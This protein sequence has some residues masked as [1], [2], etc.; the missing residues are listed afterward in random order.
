M[1]KKQLAFAFGIGIALG[2]F[3]KQQTELYQKMTP[4]KA[5]KEAKTFFKQKGQINGSWIYMKPE[6]VEKDGL[7]Y[8]AYRGGITQLE[9]GEHKQYEFL[10]DADS[11]TMIESQLHPL[12]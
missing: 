4:E 2:Y 3:V 1:N 10:V 7:L 9:N 12:K 11:G 5:L 8:N 6:Q